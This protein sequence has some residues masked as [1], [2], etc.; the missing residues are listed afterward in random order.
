MDAGFPKIIDDV[1][2]LV[3]LIADIRDPMMDYKVRP[4]SSHAHL[5]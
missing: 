3:D 5:D 4:Q 1:C 2:T